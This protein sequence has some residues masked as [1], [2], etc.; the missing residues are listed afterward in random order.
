M[1]IL[2]PIIALVW[3]NVAT[4]S[5][6]QP[7]WGPDWSAHVWNL[8]CELR[9]DYYIPFPADPDRRG[10]LSGTAFNKAFATFRA[11][12]QLHGDLI[13]TE[14]LG[15]IRFHLYVYPENFP[16]AANDRIVEATLSGFRSR[17]NVVSN[18]EIH[19]FSLNEHESAQLLQRFVDNEIVDFELTFANGDERQFKMYPSGDRTLYVLADMFQTCIRSHKGRNQ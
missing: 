19:M 17:A 16:I 10:F 4:A 1:K 3:A 9:R 2:A 11:N 15:V 6:P 13:P 18:A 12:T 5:D 14:S 8:Y 7:S